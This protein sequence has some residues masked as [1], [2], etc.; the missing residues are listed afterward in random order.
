[1]IFAIYK[2]EQMVGA[3]SALPL[4]DEEADFQKPFKNTDYNIN[5]IFYFGE[6]LLLPNYRG[7]GFGHRF[8]DERETHAKSFSEYKKACFCAVNRSA[9]HPFRP[10]GY[11][12]LDEFWQKRGY[13]KQESL[14]A[15]YEW[16][17][18]GDTEQTKKTLT[19]WTK[20]L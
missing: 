9:H 17:D 8:F 1:M 13:Q 6:S 16:Q 7:Q 5:T 14:V 18:V 19:F 20:E 15:N 4:H 11:Q 3:T 12:P 2:D 10:D